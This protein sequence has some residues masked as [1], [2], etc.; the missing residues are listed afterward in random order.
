ML[1][2]ILAV[3][4][5]EHGCLG[6]VGPRRIARARIG[7]PLNEIVRGRLRVPRC[8]AEPNQIRQRVVAETAPDLRV[9]ADPIRAIQRLRILDVA[10]PIARELPGDRLGEDLFVSRHPLETCRRHERHHRV[11]DRS[12]GRPQ[13]DRAPS[14]QTLVQ[15][16]RGRQLSRSIFRMPE[17]LARHP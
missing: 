8:V 10:V 7:K 15:R 17:P 11:R 6:P 9:P 3:E 2:G 5:D 16:H 13:A 1:P 4:D 12:L 14:E